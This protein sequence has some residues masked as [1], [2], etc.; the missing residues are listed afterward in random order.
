MKKEGIKQNMKT[1][2]FDAVIKKH[3]SIDAAFIEFP[4]DVKKEFGVNGQV[5]VLASFD[6]YEY[7]GSLANMGY[8][9]HC[10]GITK[11]VRN[12]IGKQAG[13]T[14][15]VVIKKDDK[16]RIIEIPDDFMKL[17]RENEN[18]KNFFDTLSY[19]NRKEYVEWITSAKKEETRIRRT[20]A[21]INMLLNR[22]KR[23]R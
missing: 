20:E 5:K 7:R 16:P 21:S 9:C 1:Y 19:S 2:K 17:L 15:H 22:V 12:K 23:P 11:E 3:E 18:A 13:D 14:V 6:G 8:F 4:Y 10:L